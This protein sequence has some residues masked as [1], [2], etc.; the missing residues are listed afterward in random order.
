M[1]TSA[2]FL[3]ADHLLL[4]TSVRVSKILLAVNFV[5][6]ISPSHHAHEGKR[7]DLRLG[8]FLVSRAHPCSPLGEANWGGV[9][10]REGFL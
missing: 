2:D 3:F 9:G 8:G 5:S 1:L 7:C 4:C 6:L 10:D